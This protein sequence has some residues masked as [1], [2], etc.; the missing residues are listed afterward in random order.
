MCTLL[1][2]EGDGHGRAFDAPN[3]V[4]SFF[5]AADRG[6]M[7]QTAARNL[8][9]YPS[10]WADPLVINWARCAWG[11]QLVRV[12][13]RSFQSSEP[14]YSRKL[15]PIPCL[16]A[17]WC[18]TSPRVLPGAALAGSADYAIVQPGL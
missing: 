2:A 6:A 8:G 10:P 5:P 17:G 7:A 18:D 9:M 14:A 4:R 15:P 1:L 3:C 13:G 16:F 12:M 11:H